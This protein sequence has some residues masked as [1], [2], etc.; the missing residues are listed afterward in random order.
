MLEFIHDMIFNEKRRKIAA[1]KKRHKKLAK[2]EDGL[3]ESYGYMLIEGI[4]SDLM[5]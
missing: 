1:H 4:G 3:A 2:F 5:F